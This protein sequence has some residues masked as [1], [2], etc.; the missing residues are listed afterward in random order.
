MH[1]PIQFMKNQVK[2]KALLNFGKNVNTITFVYIAKLGFKLQQTN[3]GAQKI[4]SS[5]F[6]KFKIILTS[7]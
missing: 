6:K 4:Y 1:Y 2:I 7:F 5:I 3:I